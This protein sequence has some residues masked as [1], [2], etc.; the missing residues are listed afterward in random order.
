M[1]CIEK[2]DK[3]SII[4][5]LTEQVMRSSGMSKEESYESIIELIHAWLLVVANDG[6]YLRAIK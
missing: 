2:N 4:D 5:L 6:V 1:K 3:T